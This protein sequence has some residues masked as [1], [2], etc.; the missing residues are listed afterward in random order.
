MK[1]SLSPLQPVDRALDVGR[2]KPADPIPLRLV[3]PGA[4]LLPT[5]QALEPTPFGTAEAVFHVTALAEGVLPDCRLEVFRHGKLEAIPLQLR[6]DGNRALVWLA[7][8]TVLVPLLLFLPAIWPGLA[9]G[10]DVQRVVTGWF[11]GA[12]VAVGRA[13]Q[14]A[15]SFLATTGRNLSVSF[16]TF[17][18]LL[19]ATTLLAVSRRPVVETASSEPFLL[20]PSAL[21]AKAN[22]FPSLLAPVSSGDFG[23]TRH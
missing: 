2:K 15:Y 14:A 13:A 11:P 12:P 21:A 3:I 23:D 10:G 20:M 6:S 16:F 22:P 18:M 8:L 9:E 19:G 7:A 17:L 5:E 1:V 4:I